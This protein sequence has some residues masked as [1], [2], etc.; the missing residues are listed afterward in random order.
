M[1]KENEKDETPGAPAA[2]VRKPAEKMYRNKTRMTQNI[3]IKGVL[4]SVD[5]KNT[6]MLDDETA[7]THRKLFEPVPVSK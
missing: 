5:P 4:V 3:Y 2:R 6:V 7:A 1:A